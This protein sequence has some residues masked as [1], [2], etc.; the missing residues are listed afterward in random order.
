M[1]PVQTYFLKGHIMA[2]QP[3]ASSSDVDYAWLTREEVRERV[4]AS[5]AGDSERYWAA[6]ED[7]LS[8]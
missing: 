3:K 6:V 1:L 7:L 4:L 5:K 2:G 8:E